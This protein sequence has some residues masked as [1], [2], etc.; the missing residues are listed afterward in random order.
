MSTLY[1]VHEKFQ[2]YLVTR[3]LGSVLTKIKKKWVKVNNHIVISYNK[4]LL[5]KHG[6]H[7]NIEV[8]NYSKFMKYLFKYISKGPNHPIVIVKGQ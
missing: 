6:L 1:V 4:D 2:K 8:C 7:L 3:P 5:V